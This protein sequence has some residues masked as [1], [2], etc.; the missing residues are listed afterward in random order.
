MKIDLKTIEIINRDTS[1]KVDTI[2]RV[3]SIEDIHEILT[4]DNYYKIYCLARE[5]FTLTKDFVIKFID[6]GGKESD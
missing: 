1:I 6:G 2:D 5:P 4:G 3:I